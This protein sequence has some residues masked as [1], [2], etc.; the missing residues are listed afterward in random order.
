MNRE[1]LPIVFDKFLQNRLLGV[2]L[3]HGVIVNVISAYVILVAISVRPLPL[4][5]P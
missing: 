1:V 3:E 2:C 4:H 5:L